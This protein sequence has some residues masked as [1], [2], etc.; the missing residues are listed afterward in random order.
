MSNFLRKLNVL[1]RASL[2]EVLNEVAQPPATSRPGSPISG[3]VEAMRQ[4]INEALDYEDEL[5]GRVETLQADVVR[6]DGEADDAVAGGR[7]AVARQMVGD[8]QRAQQRLA[9]AESDLRQHRL[10]TQELITRVNELEA[11]VADV[12]RAQKT[13]DAESGSEDPLENAGQAAADIIQDMRDKLAG[14]RETLDAPESVDET[15]VDDDL[16]QRR[17]RLSKK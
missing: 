12:R 15:K 1:V 3:D 8:L 2:N 6:L 9:M 4:R 5:V 17:N 16:E 13:D 11:A 7:D 10:V 14:M